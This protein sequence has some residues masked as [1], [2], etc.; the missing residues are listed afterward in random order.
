MHEASLPQSVER[1]IHNAPSRYQ[2]QQRIIEQFPFC[3]PREITQHL[4]T[5][6]Y[7][8]MAGYWVRATNGQNKAQK[9]TL[10]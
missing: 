10:K 2:R 4:G 1:A 6:W 8:K 5:L 9:L 7:P 3:P